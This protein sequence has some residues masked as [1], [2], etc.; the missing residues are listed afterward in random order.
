MASTTLGNSSRI[1]ELK[2]DTL[3]ERR[4]KKVLGIS[5]HTGTSHFVGL[6]GEGGVST[7]SYYF[8]SNN[9]KLKL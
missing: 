8:E 2:V 1:V 4:I 7:L 5:F 9:L 3:E 6:H